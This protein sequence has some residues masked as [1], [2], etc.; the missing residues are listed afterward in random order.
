MAGRHLSTQ[1]VLQQGRAV[2]TSEASGRAVTDCDVMPAGWARVAADLSGEQLVRSLPDGMADDVR[3]FVDTIASGSVQI[4]VLHAWLRGRVGPE[5]AQ[6][7]RDSSIPD[8]DD[9]SC[10]VDALYASSGKIAP[11][12]RNKSP[13]LKLLSR[14][15]LVALCAARNLSTAGT[16][17]VLIQ[18]IMQHDSAHGGGSGDVS[19]GEPAV[20]GGGESAAV[21]DVESAMDGVAEAGESSD[22]ESAVE[23]GGA[24]AVAVGAEY[25]VAGGR[26][27]GGGW[28]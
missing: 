10:I 4:A 13:K 15:A 17:P 25:A 6:M 18:L 28:C 27:R 8:V 23:G 24:P 5:G 26:F 11:K 21:V 1:D 14:P 12:K 7:Y 9:I 2:V 3:L 16:R 20:A 19:S 22:G